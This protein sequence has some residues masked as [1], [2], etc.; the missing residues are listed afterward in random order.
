MNAPEVSLDRECS[1]SSKWA[2]YAGRDILPLWV[3]DMDFKAP[4]AVLHALQQR[5]DH[6][7][8]GYA[9]STQQLVSTTVEYIERRYN[10]RI[11]PEWLLFSPGLGAS[12]YTVCRL[13]E[14]G[15]VLTPRPIYHAFRRAPSVVGARLVD[16]PFHFG[17]DGWFL[18]PAE[19][20][21]LAGPDAKVFNLCNPHNPN[22]KVFRRADLEAIAEACL[23][24]DMIISSD[25][26]HA[27]IILDE[28][29]EHIPIASLSE[30]VAARSITMMSP[31]KA[32]NVA[33][34]QFA[35]VI[36]PD[37]ELRNRYV[38]AARGWSLTH[39]NP[40]AAASTIAAWGGE[41]D[42]WL[43]ATLSYL[44]DNRDAL[45]DAVAGIPG[46]SMRHLES[47]YLAWLDV[48]ELG[49]A[50]PP[51]HFEAHGLGMSTGEEFGDSSYMR[52]NFG[53]SHAQLKE[54]ASRLAAAAAA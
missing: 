37:P 1:D 20:S 27:D 45:A 44:R 16:V 26:V 24:K 4:P 40:F 29:L 34:L 52:L 43:R 14:G 36:V 48:S 50:D 5:L 35:F 6:G 9:H 38:A 18:D 51:K 11:D 3:A 13:A 41:S 28:G 54:A 7:V 17:S 2:R 31:S 30:E 10:W 23:S 25:E 42:E 33:G 8:F 21:S 15:D 53:C 12:I 19:I 47:T 46:I 49:L 39:P 22:G 32:Y